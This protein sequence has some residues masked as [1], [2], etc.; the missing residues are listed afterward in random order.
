VSAADAADA[1][2]PKPEPAKPEPAVPE[3]EVN[4]HATP[5]SPR[6]PGDAALPAAD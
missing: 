5:P 1:A 6:S 3:P 4:G 2:A